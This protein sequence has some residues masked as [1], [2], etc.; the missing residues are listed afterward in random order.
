MRFVFCISALILASLLPADVLVAQGKTVD[1]ITK[2]DDYLKEGAKNGFS[3]AV[4]IAKDGKI[5]LNKGYGLANKEQETPNSPD[6][7]F[8]IGSVTKQFTATAILKLSEQKK[9]AV[10]D[11]LSRFFPKL[12]D[13]KKGITLHQL[14]THSAGIVDTIGDGDFDICLLYTSPSPRDKRQSRMPSSA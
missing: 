3:G 8:D 5:A 6:T 13:D 2:I 11:P 10:S 12:P 4:L 9:L 7:V 14:L 1:V